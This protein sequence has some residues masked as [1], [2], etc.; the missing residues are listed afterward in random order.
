MVVTRLFFDYLP[1]YCYTPGIISIETYIDIWHGLL[2][3][4]G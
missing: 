4:G 1:M 3:R 2:E